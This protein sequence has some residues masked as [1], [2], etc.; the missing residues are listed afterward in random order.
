MIAVAFQEHQLDAAKA[1]LVDP[2]ATADRLGVL[3]IQADAPNQRA[4]QCQAPCQCPKK[5][6][7]GTAIAIPH[8]AI[9][10]KKDESLQQAISRIKSS[11][12]ARG[13]GR[14]ITV[15]T[16]INGSLIKIASIYAPVGDGRATFFSEI[17]GGIN[18][19]TIIGIDA[20]CVLNPAVDLDRPGVTA[21][22]DNSGAPELIDL[23]THHQLVDTLR[24]TMGDSH[25]FFTNHTVTERDVRVTRTRIDQIHV[26]VID[27]MQW[28]HLTDEADFM[29]RGRRYGLDTVQSELNIIREPRGRDLKFINERVYDDD[30]FNSNLSSAIKT[31]VDAKTATDT[32]SDVWERIKV[33]VRTKSLAR[34]DELRRQKDTDIARMQAILKHIED[35]IRTG[36]ATPSDYETRDEMTKQIQAAA[37]VKRS[38]G[39]RLEKE[40]FEQGLKH[41]VST[42][43]F[44]QMWSP[45]SAAQWVAKL[46]DA[47]WSDPSKPQWDAEGGSVT[48]ASGMADAF[49]RYYEKLFGP[50]VSH[51]AS[52][53]CALRTL[54]S[55]K[56]V[57]EPTKAKLGAPITAEEIAHVSDHL[58]AGKRPGPDRIPT[59]F[60][61]T[62]SKVISPILEEVYNE[63]HS[64]TGSLPP[65]QKEGIISVLYKKKDRADARNYRPITLL[66][67]DY[68]ILMRILANRM[69]DAVSQ[70]VSDDQNGFVPNG[71][72]AENTMRLKLLQ[73]LIEEE[74]SEAIF[75]FLDCEKAF[76][77]C[78][79][80]FLIAGLEALNFGDDFIKYIK[81]AYSAD[82]PPSRRMYVN[83]HLSDPF[84]ILS[85]VAQ[86]CPLSPLLFL[87][88]TEPLARMINSDTGIKGIKVG[89]ERHKI[90]LFA[91]DTTLMMRLADVVR[92]LATLRIWERATAMKENAGKREILPVGKLR[93]HP[94][95]VPQ[96][97]TSGGAS[98]VKEG[99]TI[100]HLGIPLGN[101]IDMAAWWTDRYRKVKAKTAFWRG[102][103]RLS[104]T[105]RNMLLQ[106]ILYGSLRYWFFTCEPEEA[107]LQHIEEDAKQLL[108]SVNPELD[109]DELGTKKRARRYIHENASYLPQKE[110]GGSIMHLK[111]H[112]KAFQAQWLIKYVDPRQSPWKD[113]A[114]V[115]LRRNDRL[116]R[117]S[118]MAAGR[119]EHTIPARCQFL[120]SCL[121]SFLEI[122]VRQD[123]TYFPESAQSES[124]WRNNRFTIPIYHHQSHEWTH[125]MDTYRLH[126]LISAENAPF[127]ADEWDAHI[128]D[129]ARKNPHL[130]EAAREKWIEDRQHERPIVAA[131]VPGK[132]KKAIREEP[133]LEDGDYALVETS[134]G[135]QGYVRY[136]NTANAQQLE[137][138]TLDI[139]SFPHPTGRSIPLSQLPDSATITK[140]AVWSQLNRQYH[141][142]YAGEVGNDA[143]Q[144]KDAIIGPLTEAFPANEGWYAEGQK[145]RKNSRRARADAGGNSESEDEGGTEGDPRSLS[146][147]TIGAMTRIFTRRI[148]EGVRPNCEANWALAWQR[149]FGAPMPFQPKWDE[150]WRSFGTPLS[151]PSEEKAWRKLLHRAWNAKNRHPKE[152]DKA[153]RHKC[154]CGNESMIH[155]LTCVQV[156][157][158]WK[159]CLE[160]AEELFP[161]GEHK[162]AEAP[163][164]ADDSLMA[165]VFNS[166][167]NGLY[168][169][170][171]RAF[172]RHAVGA[173]YAEA[174]KTEKE[175]TIFLWQRA[176]L[177]ALHSFRGAVVKW[178]VEIKRMYIARKH[179]FLTERVDRKTYAKYPYLV[180]FEFEED[181]W[182]TN[183]DFTL[184]PIFVRVINDVQSGLDHSI[185]TQTNTA[186]RP[187]RPRRQH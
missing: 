2:V 118:I 101:G 156:R 186:P 41:D 138:V 130:S 151:D 86:G 9:E 140:A 74:D 67:V 182:A 66:N 122:D 51:P 61:K 93:R 55:G 48:A 113:V 29:R 53:E 145:P 132:V 28:T 58:P 36:K 133:G 77:R 39:E 16:L 154:G 148:T 167:S 78:S 35:N 18:S 99:E 98:P 187:Q 10:L 111:S 135:S 40:A 70:F 128:E 141:T 52:R 180:L 155:M 149:A 57:L 32:W 24:E 119:I 166:S 26:P 94:E 79:W 72:I 60:Y 27:A 108:W 114:D 56:K 104:L 116:G 96:E 4:C 21:P 126:D 23:L 163:S 44:Y 181:P 177:N 176:L 15:E 157:R 37:R 150:I 49:A 144:H 62:F 161:A 80:D 120:R 97:L 179:T 170:P 14:M 153:C 123:T 102:L 69:V 90:S 115:W 46:W 134:D 76:D 11:A 43:A 160:I 169:E 88:I 7:G 87:I 162:G 12:K 33:T 1:R 92:V 25:R 30:R 6:K 59:K 22:Y 100:I 84:N 91:D 31:I 17:K 146:D 137:E 45:R 125:N 129:C 8:T 5:P 142:P 165:I 103:G 75:L 121:A 89:R 112:I 172:F 54:R 107:L 110:G 175:G 38:I 109:P 184:G 68:K 158:L 105:G 164:T 19:S 152:P 71:F 143:P 20:N 3:W 50:K 13:D 159:S 65:S 139:S 185:A 85:G 81:L 73:S 168:N 136:T 183:S 95:K 82:A 131:H 63:A 171:T 178:A 124:L 117:G 106:S 83:G 173:M 147:L 127:T 47:D 64:T 34:T 42:A 174:T